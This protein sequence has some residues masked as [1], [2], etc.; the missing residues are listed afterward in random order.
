MNMFTNI[1]SKLN[2]ENVQFELMQSIHGKKPSFLSRLDVRTL[3]LWSL[4][5]SAVPWFLFDIAQLLAVFAF[6]SAITFMSKV[7]K[8]VLSLFSLGIIGQTAGYAIMAYLWGGNV[9][10]FSAV[11]V[12]TIKLA[13]VSLVNIAVFS[14]VVP[15]KLSDALSSLGAPTQF[16]FAVSYG[17]RIIPVILEEYYDIIFSFRLRSHPPSAKRFKMLHF[18][19]YILKIAVLAFYPLILNTAKR[20]RTTTEALEIKGFSHAMNNSEVKRLKLSYLRITVYDVFFLVVS[21]LI[22]TAILCFTP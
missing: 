15:E 18:V 7:N 20:I 9:E 13:I 19:I 5:F 16:V 8:L 4:I 17:Y 11:F 14:S 1:L 22:L 12:L 10:A 3:L 2:F 21:I 6:I